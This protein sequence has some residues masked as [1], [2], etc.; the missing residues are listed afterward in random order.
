MR[1]PHRRP[2]QQGRLPD[3][4]DPLS[5]LRHSPVAIGRSSSF[6]V[7]TE[8][9]QRS[10]T[11]AFIVARRCSHGCGNEA[12][13]TC[14][15]HAWVYRLDGQLIGAPYMNR[16]VDSN[17]KAFDPAD[18]HLTALRLEEWEGFLFVTQNRDAADR[19]A[20]ASQ[21]SPRSSVATAWPATCRCIA[22]STCGTPTG[23][24]S[25]R[26]SWTPTTCSRCT[27]TA[28]PRT[29][30]TRRRPRCTPATDHCA[31]HLVGHDADATS[32]VAHPANTSLEG[33]WRHTI[34]LGAA[35]PTHVM[36]L[37]PDWLWYLQLSPL[38]VDRV[39]I[40]WDVSVAPEVL[41]DQ[42]DPGAYVAKLA[43]PAQPGQRRGP[44]DRRGRVPRRASIDVA[45]AAR[46]RTS[47][48]TSTTSIATSPGR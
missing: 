48:A 20:L 39:R 1:R 47:S 5:R 15:Y 8:R 42:P 44:A 21:G 38:G 33:E 2:P 23:S 29:A 36:Q 4:R 34:V 6:A 11:C 7:T 19:S 9:S 12:R 16:T 22:R 30:T 46:C 45:L 27:R 41:A 17:G 24:C 40:R 31:Y 43:R 35:F 10:T 37:Q 25:T 28:S 3:R 13:I 14:P 18:H 26:T 32:G